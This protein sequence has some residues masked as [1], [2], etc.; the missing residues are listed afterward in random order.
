MANSTVKSSSD[1]YSLVNPRRYWPILLTAAVLAES[2]HAPLIGRVMAASPLSVTTGKSVEILARP[3]ERVYVRDDRELKPLEFADKNQIEDRRES[4]W[5]KLIPES[6]FAF[7]PEVIR[8]EDPETPRTGFIPMPDPTAPFAVATF[9]SGGGGSDFSPI[10]GEPT[11]SPSFDPAPGTNAGTP[12]QTTGTGTVT[13]GVGPTA[14][15]EPGS[16]ILCGIGLVLSCRQRKS[17]A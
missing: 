11:I 4:S 5:P 7:H 9:G 14:V 13:V 15:P 12:T 2:A 17:R 1:N 10:I 16:A 3:P 6:P 8:P